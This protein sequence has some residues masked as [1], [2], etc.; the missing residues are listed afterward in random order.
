MENKS[1]A[2]P[3]TLLADEFAKYLAGIYKN[4][5][6]PP[7]QLTQ[8]ENA[9]YGAAAVAFVNIVYKNASLSDEEASVRLSAF[10]E[11]IQQFAR[12]R[13]AELDRAFRAELTKSQGDVN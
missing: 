13:K 5:T 1:E 10:H 6:L 7:D 9:W 11:E 3:P 8:L 12:K 4:A 2:T